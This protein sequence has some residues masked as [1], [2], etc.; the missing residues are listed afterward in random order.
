MYIFV[1][2]TFVL[3]LFETLSEKKTIIVSVITAIAALAFTICFVV[4]CRNNGLLGT[5]GLFTFPLFGA[6]TVLMPIITVFSVYI[7]NGVFPA[8][9]HLPITF[10]Q[11][12]NNAAVN[13]TIDTIAELKMLLDKGVITQEEFDTKKKELLGKKL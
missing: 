12:Q 13:N 5:K 7:S 4:L 9:A 6:L 2:I 11:K 8:M 1:V 3:I 10:P